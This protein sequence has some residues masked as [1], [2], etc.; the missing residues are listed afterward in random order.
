MTAP[1]R[2]DSAQDSQLALELDARHTVDSRETN[3]R[4]QELPCDE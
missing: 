3:A 1:G 2:E 4:F